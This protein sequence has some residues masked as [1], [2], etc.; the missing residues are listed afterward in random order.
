MA[1]LNAQCLRTDAKAV[2]L[3]MM[4]VL[5][6]LLEAKSVDTPECMLFAEYYACSISQQLCVENS[7]RC[8]QK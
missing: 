3:L 6:T 8:T 1:R 4:V 2:N 7:I 5:M